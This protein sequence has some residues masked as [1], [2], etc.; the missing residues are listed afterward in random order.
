MVDNTILIMDKKYADVSG[1]VLML[2]HKLPV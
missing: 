2:V 1:D